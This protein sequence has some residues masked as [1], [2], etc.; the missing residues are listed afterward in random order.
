MSD[1]TGGYFELKSAT[2]FL[3]T[4]LFNILSECDHV[5]VSFWQEISQNVTHETLPGHARDGACPARRAGSRH[6]WLQLR[7]ALGSAL[8]VAPLSSVAFCHI[9]GIQPCSIRQVWR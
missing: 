3:L 8:E 7:R 5:D 2:L 9:V 4:V 6:R 1:G